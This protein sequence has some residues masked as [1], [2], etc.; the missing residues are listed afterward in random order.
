MVA[1]L[2]AEAEAEAKVA[3]EDGK[4]ENVFLDKFGWF[5]KRNGTS[6]SDG[7]IEMRTGEGDIDS[8]GEIVSWNNL[9]TTDAF[10]GECSRLRGSTEGLF[11]PGLADITDSIAF[12][13]TALCRP[14]HFT[15]SGLNSLHGIPVTTF[16]LDPANFANSTMCPSNV[17]YNNNLPTGVQNVTLCK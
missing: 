14:L 3:V 9:T 13:S 12:Y 6:W 15:K 5:Y 8:L 2:E 10:E 16:E 1:E 7:D 17:C 4:E 11:P